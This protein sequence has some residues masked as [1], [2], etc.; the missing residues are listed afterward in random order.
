MNK[1]YLMEKIIVSKISTSSIE[2]DTGMVYRLNVKM[3]CH[4]KHK[5]FKFSFFFFS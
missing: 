5:V 1:Y 2:I 3:A 4:N